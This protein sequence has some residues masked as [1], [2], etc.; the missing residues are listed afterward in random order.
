MK[1]AL[2]MI[3]KGTDEEAEVL[4]GALGSV[5]SSVD[6]IFI[7]LTQENKKVREVADLFDATVSFYEWDYH[8]GK[9]RAFNFIQVP[10][11]YDYIMWMDA[12]DMIRNPEKIKPTLEAN[13]DVDL[14]QMDYLYDFDER[15][16]PIIVH[17]RTQIIKNNGSVSWVGVLHEG[18]NEN[19]GQLNVK[20]LKCGESV[21]LASE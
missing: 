6:G 2:A 19:R 3:V 8:F 18:F 15:K 21:H 7:T 11:E 14:W 10:K 1:L 12:D 16:M 9:A 20:C 13:P 4:K 5:A 17:I